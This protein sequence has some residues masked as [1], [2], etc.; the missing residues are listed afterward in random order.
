MWGGLGV[1]VS[2]D[3][4]LCDSPSCPSVVCVCVCVSDSLK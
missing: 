4:K 1:L 3:I 2:G